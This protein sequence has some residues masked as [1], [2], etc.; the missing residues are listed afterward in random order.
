MRLRFL[1]HGIRPAPPVGS[2]KY[3]SIF[4]VALRSDIRY[5]RIGKA[6]HRQP[7]ISQLPIVRAKTTGQSRMQDRANAALS[8][9][10]DGSACG[11]PINSPVPGKEV[12]VEVLAS[13]S[14]V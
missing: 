5:E 11:F 1:G 4:F 3:L 12:E 7:S 10:V 14:L 13:A 8:R 2:G 9:H 6:V